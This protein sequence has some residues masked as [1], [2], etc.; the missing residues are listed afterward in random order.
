MAQFLKILFLFKKPAMRLNDFGYFMLGAARLVVLLAALT[1]LL[2]IL[3]VLATL[4]L[5]HFP[6]L[7]D[8]FGDAAV[9]GA[10]YYPL[11]STG[12]I[13]LVWS[14]VFGVITYAAGL[15]FYLF[16]LFLAGGFRN[17]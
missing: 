12:F 7:K 11:L 2:F 17:E 1:L 10:S 14:L 6:E 16:C 8:Y 9:P 5:T 15:G 13:A 4:V 3:G